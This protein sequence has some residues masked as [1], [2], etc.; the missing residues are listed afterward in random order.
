MFNKKQIFL[1][2]PQKSS[3]LL[4]SAPRHYSLK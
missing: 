2:H 4:P 3:I 1:N